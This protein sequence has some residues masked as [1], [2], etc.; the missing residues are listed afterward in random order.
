MQGWHTPP[1]AV[2]WLS[3]WR[4]LHPESQLASLVNPTCPSGMTSSEALFMRDGKSECTFSLHL[5]E[6]LCVVPLPTH[7]SHL[8]NLSRSVPYPRNNHLLKD[9]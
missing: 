3:L 5:R 1:S 8:N 2:W 6:Y 4:G 9:T 7:V